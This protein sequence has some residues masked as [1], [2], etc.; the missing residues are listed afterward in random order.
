[1]FNLNN[2]TDETHDAI[3]TR[4]DKNQTLMEECA[5][6]YAEDRKALAHQKG[7][8]AMVQQIADDTSNHFNTG[9]DVSLRDTLMKSASNLLMRQ[10]REEWRKPL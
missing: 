5:E 8:L 6:I 7:S 9:S 2:M 1:M 4:V 10:R 3:R